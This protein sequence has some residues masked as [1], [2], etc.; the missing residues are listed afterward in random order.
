MPCKRLVKVEGSKFIIKA[1]LVRDHKQDMQQVMKDDMGYSED[2][3]LTDKDKEN[4]QTD[5]WR[6]E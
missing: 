5:D 6:D 2:T 1:L 3:N 4:D